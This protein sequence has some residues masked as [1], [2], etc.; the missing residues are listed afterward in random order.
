MSRRLAKD[1]WLDDAR[2]IAE[3]HP[4]SF[5]IPARQVVQKLAPGDQVKLI[6]SFE[7]ADP[8][9]P[10]AERMWVT[11][12][13]VSGNEFRGTLDNEPAYM[14][15]IKIG[16]AIKFSAHHIINTDLKDPSSEAFERYFKRCFVTHRIIEQSEKPGYAYREQPD[17]ED[18]SGWRFLVGDE[19][20]EYL[21][22]A[23]N[24]SCIAVGK[25][26]NQDRTLVSIFD[27]AEGSW[28]WSA[29]AKLW[30]KT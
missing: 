23:A 2:A 7:S 8:D 3:E 22:D 14:T 5:W 6:F 13:E 27:E 24:T 25:V 26:L 12:D 4:Y 15:Q 18:D 10:G 20:D 17:S 9:A 16:A 11:I 21:D 29:T 1:W 28:L 30:E 19:S